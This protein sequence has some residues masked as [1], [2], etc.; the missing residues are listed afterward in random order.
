M[1]T[2]SARV[3]STNAACW[4]VCSACAADRYVGFRTHVSSLFQSVESR[5]HTNATLGIAFA[6]DARYQIRRHHVPLKMHALCKGPC[7]SLFF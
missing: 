6:P 7:S 2:L 5:G 4:Y 3:V 1:S